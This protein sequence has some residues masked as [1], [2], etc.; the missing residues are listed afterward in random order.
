MISRE[1]LYKL[2]WSKPMTKVGEDLGVSGSY[3][4]RV[5]T[6]LNVPRPGLGYWAKLAV[7]KAPPPTLQSSRQSV[8]SIA[9]R[10]QIFQAIFLNAICRRRKRLCTLA[11]SRIETTKL[12]RVTWSVLLGQSRGETLSDQAQANHQKWTQRN[13]P[14]IGA[15]AHALNSL[16]A[17][18]ASTYGLTFGNFGQIRSVQCTCKIWG[19]KWRGGRRPA[20]N[21][22][23]SVCH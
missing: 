15:L 19:T 23:W 5:C 6:L 4:T 12:V 3:M 22:L 1:E 18:T 10:S 7:G 2:V 8:A 9:N 14:P 16:C 21:L 20:S 13:G 11:C 17:Q